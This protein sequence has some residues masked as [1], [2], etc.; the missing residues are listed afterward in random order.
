MN[1]Y[2]IK[3]KVELIKEAKQDFLELYNID[4]T[5]FTT[6]Y[7]FYFIVYNNKKY[8]HKK[9]LN[10]IYTN[11]D[12]YTRTDNPY[13]CNLSKQLNV[14]P[15]VELLSTYTGSLLPELLEENE[16]F[17]VYRFEP[18]TA[19]DSVTSDEFHYAKKQHDSLSVSPFYVSMAYNLVRTHD[20]IKLVDLKHFDVK[21]DLPFFL[22]MY[23]KE[24][25]VNTLYVE[26]KTEIISIIQF[27]EKDYPLMHTK[28]IRY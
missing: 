11:G 19:I 25:C 4:H 13:I 22:Y 17:L 7:F 10:F 20:N 15:I 23:N 5:P 24:Y 14:I 2:L 12:T 28:I 27:L 1:T 21:N 26:E 8:V 9:S 16:K 6:K 18:G 3:R